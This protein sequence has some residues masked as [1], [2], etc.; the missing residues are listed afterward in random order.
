MPLRF[1][2]CSD[3]HL[4]DLQGA[5]LGQWFNKRLTGGVNLP[6]SFVTTA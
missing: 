5:R 4:L 6:R 1:I 3:I 2:H